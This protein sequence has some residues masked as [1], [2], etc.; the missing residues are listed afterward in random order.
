ME[1]PKHDLI[2]FAAHGPARLRNEVK[3]ED[4]LLLFCKFYS[5]RS[6]LHNDTYSTT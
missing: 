6:I 5:Y 2:R 3:K 4:I 1:V